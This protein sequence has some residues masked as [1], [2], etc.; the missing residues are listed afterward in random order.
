MDPMQFFHQF[1]LKIIQI[2]PSR[3]PMAL[4]TLDPS[5]SSKS[6]A[7]GNNNPSNTLPGEGDTPA[8]YSVTSVAWAPSCGRSYHLVAT[9][10]RDGHVR[11]WQIKPAED[12]DME[13]E[14]VGKWTGTIVADFD[15]HK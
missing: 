1:P 14:T 10:C 12:A 15:N 13:D 4:L 6:S 8:P 3:R 9:G 11:I 7:E 2:S 5:P